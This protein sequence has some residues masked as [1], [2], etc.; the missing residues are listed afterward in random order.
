M[1]HGEIWQW[2]YGKI[3][4]Q[5]LNFASWSSGLTL[6]RACPPL[7]P[8]ASKLHEIWPR[9]GKEA[10]ICKTIKSQTDSSSF[11]E[12]FYFPDYCSTEAHP[13]VPC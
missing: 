1:C 10:N 12:T 9:F 13:V 3:L 7:G 6:G 11:V 4:A 5:F 8:W 2:I